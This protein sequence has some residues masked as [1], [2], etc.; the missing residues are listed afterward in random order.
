M[1]CMVISSFVHKHCV[2][3]VQI[4]SYFWSVSSCIRTQYRKIRTRNNSVLGQFS[5]RQMFFKKD[6]FKNFA[7]LPVK[8]GKFLRTPFSTEH[9]YGGCFY[10]YNT[11]LLFFTETESSTMRILLAMTPHWQEISK[12]VCQKKEN[13]LFLVN[14]VIIIT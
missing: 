3:I 13:W 6:V 2:K 4:R 7:N 8:F 1:V 12:P 9:L 5:R 10:F 14:I 11:R